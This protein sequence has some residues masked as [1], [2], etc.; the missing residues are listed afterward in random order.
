[1][2]KAM[3]RAVVLAS[4]LAPLVVA[5][6]AGCG[7]DPYSGETLDDAGSGGAGGAI[8]LGTGGTRPVVGPSDAAT[9]VDA[10]PDAPATNSYLISI[11]LVRKLDLLFMID[12]SPSMAPKVS[13]LNAQF[14]KLIAA[15]K[16]PN[17]GTYP[18]LRVALIDSDLGTGGQYNNGNP[19]SPNASNGN[20]SYGDLGTFQMRGATACGM[21]STDALWIDYAKGQ[22]VNY[23]GDIGKVFACLATNLGTNG[24]GEEHQLQSYEF[25]FFANSYHTS[26]QNT[27][28]RPE[29]HLGLVFLSDEDDCSAAT[30]DG[31]FGDKPELRGES[32]SLRCATRGHACGG[33]SLA[34]WGPNYPTTAKFQSDFTSCTARTDSCSDPLDGVTGTDTTGPTSCTPLRSIKTLADK[35]KALKGD[36]ANDKIFVAGIFGW[37]LAGGTAEP[38]KIDLISNPNTADTAHPQIFDYWPVCYDPDHRP[39]TEGAYDSD[40]WAWGA[41]GGLRM[42]AFVDQ[43]GANGSKYSIC[44]RDFTG[45]MQG[46]GNTLASKLANRCV[47]SD[48]QGKTC[49]AKYRRPIAVG[50]GIGYVDDGNLSTCPSGATDGAT[51]EDCFS[52]VSDQALCPGAQLLVR[53]L[54]TADEVATGPIA[55][56][57]D[58]SI[59]CE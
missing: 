53:V 1:M 40:A 28:L 8:V 42:S 10:A 35:I 45:A 17:D 57:T 7:E 16:D 52:L 23:S 32:A 55:Q 2:T 18:D 22:P 31:M 15:L 30:D 54:R 34:D 29:A 24:C 51:S 5:V 49:T 12:N 13:K 46:F 33:H 56:G 47:P 14:P 50:S 21:T 36:Q 44:E 48:I 20:S 26:A 6:F 43:F 19:C 9:T 41:Q 38:Y 4:L 25:A 59:T 37:P 39:Q 11:A 3:L 58:L 27:F